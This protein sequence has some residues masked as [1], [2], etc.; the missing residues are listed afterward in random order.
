MWKSDPLPITPDLGTSFNGLS[1]NHSPAPDSGNPVTGSSY[2]SKEIAETIKVFGRLRPPI[3]EDLVKYGLGHTLTST[4][5]TFTTK[6]QSGITTTTTTTTTHSL[7]DTNTN[8]IKLFNAITPNQEIPG[9]FVYRKNPDDE[10]LKEYNFH[11]CFGQDS[12]Q[13]DIYKTS[14]AKLVQ[15]V[16]EGYNGAVLAYGQTGSGKT[17]TMRGGENISIS[18]SPKKSFLKPEAST[19]SESCSKESESYE[20]D[21]EEEEEVGSQC[22]N[23]SSLFSPKKKHGKISFDSP[24]SSDGITIRALRDIFTWLNG[25]GGLNAAGVEIHL[26]YLQIYCEML[27]DLLEPSNSN[28]SLREKEGKVYVEGLSRINVK[29]LKQCEKVLND[30]DSNRTTACTKLNAQ[31]S[32]S[33]AV[34]MVHITR[35]EADAKDSNQSSGSN[36]NLIESTLFL[37]DLAGSERAK[38][39]GAIMANNHLR[40]EE[41][42]AINLSLSALG[43]CIFALSQGRPHIPFRDSKLTRLLQQSLGGNTKTS[44]IVCLPPGTDDSGETNNSLLFG[45]RASTVPVRASVNRQVDYALLYN[46]LQSRLDVK[47]DMITS[48][49]IEKGKLLNEFNILKGKYEALGFEKKE[50]EQKLDTT[51][52]NYQES[53]KALQM[54]SNSQDTNDYKSTSINTGNNSETYKEN[55]NGNVLQQKTDSSGLDT[56]EAIETINAK[57]RNEIEDL[58][59]R[60]CKTKK[61]L[62]EKYEKRLSA[63]K[64]A[65]DQA[66]LNAHNIETDLNTE[67]DNHLATLS[68]FRK[69]HERLLQ[70]ESE[71]A[72]RIADLLA[73]TNEKTNA[74]EEL[75]Q[76]IELLK[77]KSNELNMNRQGEPATDD[78]K[79]V[80]TNDSDL[81]VAHKQQLLQ[82]ENQFL[83]VI[84]KL[85]ERVKVLEGEKSNSSSRNRYSASTKSSITPKKGRNIEAQ[86]PMSQNSCK[87]MNST[88]N[89]TGHRRSSSYNSSMNNQS[90]SIRNNNKLAQQNG[91]IRR[92]TYGGMSSNNSV[93]S[94]GSTNRQHYSARRSTSRAVIKPGA[95]RSTRKT[96]TSTTI[97]LSTKTIGSHN[98]TLSNRNNRIINRTTPKNHRGDSLSTRGDSSIRSANNNKKY[99]PENNGQRRLIKDPVKAYSSAR[100]GHLPSGSIRPRKKFDFLKAGA[101]TA[102]KVASVLPPPTIN[103]GNK[104]NGLSA[105]AAMN[106]MTTMQALNSNANVLSVMGKFQRQRFPY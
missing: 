57:W 40:F 59:N 73:E 20:A 24:H 19:L 77:E 37:V 44:L 39:S 96:S 95:V 65:I 29:T 58:E 31:S 16:I 34:L 87:W 43:N 56:V 13:E 47:D 21:F 79:K 88:R 49:Q 104:N 22:S 52:K 76:E 45:Q 1:F 61:A 97:N 26:S 92:H 84:N 71:S 32:R 102:K 10:Q 83:D 75:Q 62:M 42:K 41:L 53:Y 91:H 66:N 103:R 46:S 14:V 3:Q 7:N 28:L 81:T 6:S 30:G 54:I 67:R 48:L 38:K 9:K 93:T 64:V 27:Q 5:D 17:Y 63:F 82:I 85:Q 60:N 4:S 70:S 15:N 100:P 50:L 51:T 11:G 99:V 101:G 36:P 90:R 80:I 86:S 23:K 89:V 68:D 78:I 2:T 25:T 18:E 106:S 12:S 35:S 98:M 8:N 55:N 69:C 74:I 72:A 33:H 105:M 94:N